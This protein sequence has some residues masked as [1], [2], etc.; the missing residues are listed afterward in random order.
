STGR[1]ART[2][3]YQ[4]TNT[5]QTMTKTYLRHWRGRIASRSGR[6]VIASELE[7]LEDAFRQRLDRQHDQAPPPRQVNDRVAAGIHGAD[8][9]AADL[10]R[11]GEER[12][13]RQ[14]GRHR[15]VDEARLQGEHPHSRSLQPLPE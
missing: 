13:L 2:P 15:G 1:V 7:P 14:G 6:R 11:T 4:L 8:D 12:R 9:P 3:T 10:R 5:M